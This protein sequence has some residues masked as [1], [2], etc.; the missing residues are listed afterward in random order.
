MGMSVTISGATAQDTE[1]I[2]KLQYLCYQGEAELYGDYSIEPLT[3]TLDALRA[4]LADG[5]GLVARLGDEVVASVRGGVDA[6]GT[7]RIAKLIV[8]PRMQRHGI[9]GRLLTA[10]ERQFASEAAAKR[11]QLFTG[12][13]S[14]GNLRLYRSH[15]YVPVSTE[16]VGRA[17]TVV[18]LEKEA[19][20]RAYV[21]SA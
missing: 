15:G 7:V 6:S 19:G 10:I 8:H 12:Q 3:Q 1:Q 21:Q 4:E 18:T 5:Y 9:G 16:R 13:R 14:E 20:A 2:L 11:F 17:L